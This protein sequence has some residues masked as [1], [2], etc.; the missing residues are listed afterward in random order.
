MTQNIPYKF[1]PM[2]VYHLNGGSIEPPEPPF[3][4]T[5]PLSFTGKAATNAVQLSA[6]GSPDA[7]ELSYSK[8]NGTWTTYSIGDIIEMT[9]GD[10]VAFSGTNDHFSKSYRNKYQFKMTGTIE[11]KGNIQSLMNFSDSCTDYCYAH[12]FVNCTSLTEAP[13]L[14][15]TTLNTDCYNEMFNG[16]TS[17]TSAPQ[18]PATTLCANCYNSMFQG[19]SNLSSAP[20]L[21]A[22]TLANSCYRWMFYDC[23]SLSSA[24]QLPATTLAQFCYES[25]FE[26]CSNLSSAPQLPATTLTYGCYYYMF[27]G[28]SKLSSINVSFTNWNV[29]YATTNWVYGVQTTAGTFTCPTALGTDS[30][31]TRGTSNCPTN[32]TVINK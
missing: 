22:T 7:I 1:N 28:C 9:V 23:S 13:T 17:L 11:A 31:I 3:D 6:V 19:C 20:Q 25:M 10:T 8:N 26:G 4:P 5:T 24:P 2:P 15:A 12:M 29:N 16:C 30:T 27:Y 32:W 21:P 18:L 14:P